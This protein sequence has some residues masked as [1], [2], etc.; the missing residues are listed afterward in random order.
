MRLNGCPI[1][2]GCPGRSNPRTRSHAH[3]VANNSTER[4][5]VRGWADPVLRLE[6]FLRSGARGY[7]AHWPEPVAEA[8]C[9]PEQGQALVDWSRPGPRLRSA[10]RQ[11][12]SQTPWNDVYTFL[13]RD[14][15]GIAPLQQNVLLGMPPLHHF[16]VVERHLHLP[17]V[18]HAQQVNTFQV[19]KLSKARTGKRLQNGHSWQEGNR[20]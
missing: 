9:C 15:H 13:L 4:R 5:A 3:Q 20:S 2:R 17:A 7:P 1:R 19:R 18:L 6:D 8:G 11:A 12:P 10:P 16:L 14:H